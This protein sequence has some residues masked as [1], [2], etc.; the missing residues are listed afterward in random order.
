MKTTQFTSLTGIEWQPA[1]SPDGEQIVFSHSKGGADDSDIYV[2]LIGTTNAVQRTNDPRDERSPVFSPDGRE[3]AF[4]R[5]IDEREQGIYK[6]PALGGPEKKLYS[7][8][9]N[10]GEISWD[11]TGKFMAVA[12]QDST[13]NPWRIYLLSLA[14]LQMKALTSPPGT[15]RGDVGCAFSPDGKKLAFVRQ[16]SYSVRDIYIIPTAGGE[17]QRITFDNR[18]IGGLAW[19][20]NGRHIVFSSNRGGSLT[21][22]RVALKGGSP[23]PVI[24]GGQNIIQPAISRQRQ[25]L[26]YVDNTPNVNIWQLEISESKKLITM[27][28]EFISSTR[29]DNYA[30]VSPDGK[31]I[32]FSS[33]RSGDWEIWLCDSDGEDLV[34]LTSYGGPMAGCPSWSPDGKTV[35]FNC[36]IEGAGD[37]FMIDVEGAHPRQITRDTSDDVVPS[38]SR[39]GLWIYFASNRS[40]SYQIWKIPAHGGNAVQVTEKGGAVAFESSDGNWLYYAKS[41]E[42]DNAGVTSAIWKT[43]VQGGDESMVFDRQIGTLSWALAEEGIYFINETE[44]SYS[45]EF[46]SFPTGDV[47]KITKLGKD[48]AGYLAVSFDHRRILYSRRERLESDI[49]LVENFR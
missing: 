35:A 42:P 34:Q 20:P 40:G 25:R 44:D 48:W 21:L 49:L 43:S 22:W 16:S 46:L 29:M 14:T 36:R 24:V 6:I 7:G 18:R 5:H 32:V 47:I 15:Y 10:L 1:F 31:K 3:I 41:D 19:T 37:I 27:P 28:S 30:R 26:V 45:L 13:G 2:Q 33:W 39:D 12:A 9:W 38:W 8:S 17:P 11:P 23:E 4:V